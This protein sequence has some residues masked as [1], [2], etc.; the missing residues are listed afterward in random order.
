[1]AGQTLRVLAGLTQEFARTAAFLVELGLRFIGLF[2]IA[3]QAVEPL[4]NGR[5]GGDPFV[6]GLGY[7]LR[8]AQHLFRLLG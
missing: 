6:E 2:E 7:R 5:D 3:I 8:A 1:M 4:V